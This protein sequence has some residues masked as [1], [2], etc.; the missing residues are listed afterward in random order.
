M[1]DM[2]Y[3]I[4]VD[5]EKL[6]CI[7]FNLLVNVFKFI[8]ENGK[9][10]VCFVVLQKDGVFFFCFMVVNIG[11]LILVEY[12]C[13]IFDW[14]YK[15]DRYYIGFGIGLVLVKVFVEIYG[16]SISVESDEWLGIVFIVDLL[17]W[18]C[19]E[20]VCVVI[21]LM[22]EFVLDWVDSLFC[23]DE[24]EN[25]NDLFKFFVFVIDDNVDICVYVYM[26]FNLE[27]LII[28]VVDGIEGICKVMKY[29]FDVIILDVMMLGI[30]GIECCWRLKGEL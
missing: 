10:I 30:D 25:L 24:V 9:V 7:Y 23:E 28:E 29:V 4:Q 3:Y 19:E 14:F 18:I 5:V 16:G 27:Y 2:D 22:E 13:S 20:G 6:E 11:S 21:V 12:I 1:F 15:I 8:L 17:V 26:L